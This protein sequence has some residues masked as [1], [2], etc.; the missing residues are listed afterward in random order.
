MISD[1]RACAHAESCVIGRDVSNAR[2]AS[3]AAMLASSSAFRQREEHLRVVVERVAVALRDELGEHAPVPG[4]S[5]SS[6][7]SAQYSTITCPRGQP[8]VDLHQLVVDLL[9]PALVAHAPFTPA[10]PEL[11]HEVSANG[12]T[13]GQLR[14]GEA[15][16][17]RARRRRSSGAAATGW[18]R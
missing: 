17:A 4:G 9:S 10:G 15:R 16:A 5:S 6:G 1:D 18:D 12:F 14:R 2:F 7:P 3:H 8:A 11:A 13:P